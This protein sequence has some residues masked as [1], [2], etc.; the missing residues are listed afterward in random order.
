MNSYLI[1]SHYDLKLSDMRL[2][3][4]HFG[5]EIYAVDTEP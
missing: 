3:D 4:E 5:T 1:E 2:L